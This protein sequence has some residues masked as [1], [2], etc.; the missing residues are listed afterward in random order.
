MRRN[1]NINDEFLEKIGSKRPVSLSLIK[2]HGN[3]V[4]SS[5]L[6]ELFRRCAEKL[7][8]G[9]SSNFQERDEKRRKVLLIVPS[10]LRWKVQYDKRRKVRRVEEGTKRGGR[11]DERRKVRREE[12]GTKRGGR[13]EERRKVR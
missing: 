4:T 10:S 12:E 2:C 11:C 1:H 3:H 5:G 8:V 7:E 6:R 13:Y 9:L